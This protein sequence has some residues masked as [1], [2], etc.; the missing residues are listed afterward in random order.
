ME[1]K[2]DPNQ[3]LPDFILDKFIKETKKVKP[4]IKKIELP[5]NVQVMDSKS[6]LKNKKER[7]LE[8][9][10]KMMNRDNLKRTDYGTVIADKTKGRVPSASFSI[11]KEENS[12]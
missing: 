2:F 6:V 1:K 4:E 12:K 9:L 11:K 10:N 8:E 5:P 3:P 7:A